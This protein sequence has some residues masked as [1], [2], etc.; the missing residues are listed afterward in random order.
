MLARLHQINQKYDIR[1]QSRIPVS[2]TTAKGGRAE[3]ALPNSN[4]VSYC[5]RC[6]GVGHITRECPLDSIFT[7]VSSRPTVPQPGRSR[8]VS[9]LEELEE[10]DDDRDDTCQIQ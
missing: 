3:Q 10:A 4:F 7:R 2:S 6:Y 5:S 9:W 8:K 1:Y